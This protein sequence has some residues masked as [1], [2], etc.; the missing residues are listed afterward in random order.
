MKTLFE[1]CRPRESVF[2]ETKRDDVLDLTD[3]IENRINP[4]Q[5]FEENYITQGMSIL[6]DTAFKRFHRQGQTGIIKLTQSMGGGKTH[7]MIALGLLAKYPRI[8][9][10]ILGEKYRNSHLGEIKV[11][12]F[13]GRESD[14]PFGIWGSIAEQ[15]GKKEYFK[16]YYS[17]LQAPGQTAW[18]NLL[19]GEPLLILLDELPPY[20]ENA[21]SK[22]IGDTNL[23]VITTTALANLFNAIAKEE[24][25]N[26]CLVVSDLKASYESG[27]ELL[28]SSFKEL[29]GEINRFALNIEPVQQASD[30]VYHILRKRLFKELP[31]MEE[32]N[33]VANA[34]K[35]AVNEARQMGYTSIS[36][37]QVY[38]GIKD[39]YPFH[40]VIKDLYA[41]FKENPGFQ[42][43]RGLIRLMRIIINQ[44]YR[45]EEPLAAKKYLVNVYDFDLNDHEMFTAITQIKPS[46]SNAISHDIASN[47]KAVAEIYDRSL[48]ETSM[49]EISKIIL[50]ASLADVPHALLGLSEHEI[51]GYLCE[52]NKDITRIKRALQELAMRAWYL[53]TD[54]DGRIFFQNIKNIIAEMNSLIDSYDNESAKK[55]LRTFLEEKFKPSLADCYQKL[56]VFPALD[57][58]QLEQDKISLI[59]V[60]PYEL[61][62][63]LNPE[64]QKFYEYQRFKN[65]V[66]F[67]TGQRR[68][69]ENLYTKAKEHKAINAI[70]KR[71]K[72]ERIKDSDPQFQKAQDKL[73]KIKLEL[74]QTARE[75]FQCLYY[76]SKYGLLKVDFIMQFV[77]NEYNGEKQIKEVLIQ[78]QKFTTD[79]DDDKLRQKCEARLFTQKEMRWQDIKERAAINPEWQWHEPSALDNL[80]EN[81]LRKDIWR[82]NGGYVDKGPFPKEKTNVLIQQIRY[83]E[84]TGEAVLRLTPQYGN[85][86]YYEIDGPATSASNLVENPNEFKTKELKLSFVC[87]DS[88][89]EHE[90]G[91]PVYWTNKIT[92]KGRVYDKNGKKVLELKANPNVKIKYTTDGS[93]PKE[94]GGIYEGE[95]EIPDNTTIILAVAEE[96]GIYSEQI[97]IKVEKGQVNAREIDKSRKL[98]L[99]KRLKFQDTKSTYEELN[100]LKKHNV[101]VSD[102]NI[103]LFRNDISSSGGWIDLSMGNDIVCKPDAIETVLDN[104]RNTLVQSGSV[105][106]SFEYSKAIFETGQNFL[107]YIADKK[108]TLTE[109]EEREI[110]Q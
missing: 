62:N 34:Y 61:S 20:L 7:N 15:L 75:T 27:S 41:R 81:M 60:E 73:D 88:N 63:D 38:I 53:N 45:G 102:V 65:R 14:A 36:A 100:M 9:E 68:T 4:E 70:I 72:E 13:T 1:L 52:P 103:I 87:I 30:E 106:I 47:G 28:Q 99:V 93:N 10:K 80:L 92:I 48:N 64:V 40:P 86:I 11:V 6:F 37:D 57:E 74:L 25:S 98:T 18:V 109:F 76:P 49:Q 105:N 55:E 46:L 32:I 42:Q 67:L 50:V 96:K 58:V 97:Q 91:D 44:L 104:I 101:S 16:D 54:R 107:D 94:N 79:L 12:A 82:Q 26:V 5:F 59:I 56:Y 31:S 71:M 17:P 89:G 39:S 24:L 108:K 95:V 84:E 78:R 29:E 3:L 69:M 35:S 2:D 77:G 66:M 21:K 19:K 110:I 23:A 43:T 22:V 83:D 8:R 85:K 90:T 33:E 51:I